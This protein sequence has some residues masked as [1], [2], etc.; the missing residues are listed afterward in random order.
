MADPL[1]P[2]ILHILPDGSAGGGATAVLGLCRD[3]LATGMWEVGLVTQPR[4]PLLE[5]AMHDD[6]PAMPLDFFQSRLD[7][8]LPGKLTQLIRVFRPDILHTHGARG[9]LPFCAM[10]NTGPLIY[11]VHGFHHAQLPPPLRLLGRLA[12]RRIAA[13]ADAIVFVSEGDRA[14]GGREHI[15][16]ESSPKSR[17]IANGIDTGDFAGITPL[18][19]RFDLVFAGRAHPQ[20]NPLFMV[21]IMEQ[22]AG[23]GLR[24]RMI[25]GGSLEGALRARIDA[26]PARN[27]ITLTGALP[28]QEVL[29]AFR[30]ARL[31]VLPSLWEGLPITPIEAL[32]CGLPV[33]ASGI[34]GTDEIILDGIN[35]RLIDRFDAGLYAEAIRKILGNAALHARLA[36]NGRAWVEQR[37]LRTASSA[38]HDELYR[39]MMGQTS[40]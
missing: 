16:P 35:G 17:V 12:E 29:R 36:A 28:R 39:R 21:D 4:S 7:F 22:L 20:K 38:K 31:Y 5:Q 9:A 15:L 40:A 8:S 13:R 33:V 37:F 18:E 19:E 27:A 25:C 3:L 14:Q 26:S 10:R 6:I 23:S 30:S 1:R 2:R 32:Y 34:S 11:T 24:L